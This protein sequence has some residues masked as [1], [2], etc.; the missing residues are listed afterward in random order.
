MFC[1]DCTA[2]LFLYRGTITVK[3]EKNFTIGEYEC[4]EGFFIKFGDQEEQEDYGRRIWI[5]KCLKHGDWEPNP[6]K[7]SRKCIKFPLNVVEKGERRQRL[8]SF[9]K[10]FVR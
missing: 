7:C 8:A 5:R 10:I 3:T 6:P 2:K 9:A 1:K 4:D